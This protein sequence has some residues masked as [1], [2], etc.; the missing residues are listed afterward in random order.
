MPS[1]MNP[2]AGLQQGPTAAGTQDAAD[3]D[4]TLAQTLQLMSG[5]GRDKEGVDADTAEAMG[6]EVMK[7]M[8]SEFE[9]MGEKVHCQP[10]ACQARTPTPLSHLPL[11]CHQEDFQTIVDGM[12]KQLL[13]KD[14][15]YMPMKQ[16]CDA[17]CRCRTHTHA[18]HNAN[19]SNGN[20]TCLHWGVANSSQSG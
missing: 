15:M 1:V 12:M 4:T 8:M 13:S 11:H 3:M 18:T 20:L 2:F 14:V 17:V 16:I 9:K 5:V 6:E 7:K 10:T 19:S